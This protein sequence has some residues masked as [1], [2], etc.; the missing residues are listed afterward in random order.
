MVSRKTLQVR[1]HSTPKN[2]ASAQIN[3]I[4]SFIFFFFFFS[5]TFFPFF[6]RVVDIFPPI[7][8]ARLSKDAPIIVM[9]P[10]LRCHS[11][12][13]PGTTLVRRALAYGMRSITVNRRGH[14]P[15]T[16]L[17]SPRWSLFGDVDDLEQVYWK[18]KDIFP[19][20][21]FFLCGLSSGCA[22]VISGLG[23]MMLIMY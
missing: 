18:L 2:L 22:L 10:G 12:D 1:F 5:N 15:N 21:I 14:T 6:F 23:I 8:D 13:L 9:L 11:Q 17:K 4:S 20:S 7:N 16:P 3:L 19:S